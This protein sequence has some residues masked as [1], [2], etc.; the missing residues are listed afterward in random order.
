[1]IRSGDPRRSHAATHFAPAERAPADA[2]Q[3]DVEFAS[4]NPVID[5]VLRAVS[6]FLAVLNEHRQI[7]TVNEALLRNLGIQDAGEVL[8]LRPGEAIRCVHADDFAGG[9]GTS[10]FCATC[11]AAIA[12]V[13]CLGSGKPEERDCIATVRRDGEKVDLYLRVRSCPVSYEGRRFVLLFLQDVTTDQRRSELERA[14]FHDVCNIITGLEGASY[15]LSQ[16]DEPDNDKLVSQIRHLVQRLTK[17]VE[18]Q[19]TL[20]QAESGQYHVA[21]EDLSLREVIGGLQSSLASHP[22]ARGKRLSFPRDIPGERLFTDLSL[23]LR[24]LMNMLIN[25][26]EATGEGG[27]VRVWVESGEDGLTFLVWNP[28][29]IPEDVSRRIFQ[30]HF[31]TKKDNGRGLGTYAMK[32]FGEKILGGKVDFTSSDAEGTVFRLWLPRVKPV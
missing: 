21:Y 10:K 14:F 1:M 18:I 22:A 19:R 32:L 25:A 26:L 3:R 29:G 2:L 6:G 17:E 28:S 13:A 8:G 20:S 16:D 27:E 7:L 12:I 30:R 4:T 9:C 11:G 15:L 31:T 24:V 5:G 23:L